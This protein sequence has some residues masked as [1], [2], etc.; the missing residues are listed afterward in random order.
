MQF[1]AAWE[2]AAA[3]PTSST[4]TLSFD[5]TDNQDEAA[6]RVAL[7]GQAPICTAASLLKRGCRAADSE[8]CAAS[9]HRH[10]RAC[11]QP[12]PLYA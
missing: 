6:S 9:C 5:G 1:G 8:K 2:A 7:Q 11:V 4:R 10:D 3:C 12:Q